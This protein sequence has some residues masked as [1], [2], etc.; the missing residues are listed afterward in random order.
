MRISDWSS[1]VCSSDIIESECYAAVENVFRNTLPALRD[2]ALP[3]KWPP[4]PQLPELVT[5]GRITFDQFVAAADARLGVS[6]YLAGD[7]FSY[8]DI[9]L[10]LALDFGRRAGLVPGGTDRK[11]TRLKSSP[12]CASRL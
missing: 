5:R 2:R 1:D 10:V 7:R 9:A 4:M 8:A 11:S 3:G 6:A 12:S